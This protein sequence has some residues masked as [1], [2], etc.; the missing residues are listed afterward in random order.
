MDIAAELK[1][2]NLEE[3]R[4][5]KAIAVLDLKLRNQAFVA[6]AP[7]TIIEDVKSTRLQLAQQL[8]E[9]VSNINSLK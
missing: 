3:V 5:T 1:R 6:K 7:V 8:V 9:I 4:L 2:L